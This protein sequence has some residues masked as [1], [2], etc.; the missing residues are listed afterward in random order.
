[1]LLGSLKLGY[2]F[3]M[4]MDYLMHVSTATFKPC[5]NIKT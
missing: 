3:Y 5:N 2:M 1:M 4:G